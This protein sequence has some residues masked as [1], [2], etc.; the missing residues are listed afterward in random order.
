VTRE[1][2]VYAIPTGHNWMGDAVHVGW[3]T[4]RTGAIS[5]ARAAGYRVMEAGG[6]IETS[7]AS[8]ILTARGRA[9]DDT[10]DGSVWTVTV[11]P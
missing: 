3:A 2:R 11:Y 10:D 7:P 8:A 9:S 4:S 6:L 5:T 1:L